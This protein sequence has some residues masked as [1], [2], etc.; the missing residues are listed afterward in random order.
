MKATNHYRRLFAASL[1]ISFTVPLSYHSLH[2]YSRSEYYKTLTHELCKAVEPKV[3]AGA[4]REPLEY[5]QGMMLRQEFGYTPQVTLI[6]H[7]NEITSHHDFQLGELKID[8]EFAG[9][10]EVQISITYQEESLFR[11]KYVYLYL[12]SLPLFFILFLGVRKLL[13]RF[14]RR[15]VDIVQSQIQKSLGL[16][17]KSKKPRGFFAQLLNL[18]IPLLTYLNDHIKNLENQIA[19]HTLQVTEQRE[20][21]LMADVA[22]QVA[23]DIVA[24]ISTVQQLLNAP[25][26]NYKENHSIVLEELERV[27][28]LAQ[29]MLRQ[30]R[31]EPQDEQ[32][33]TVNLNST[34]GIIAREAEVYAKSKT[35][36]EKLVPN[37]I[38]FTQAIKVEITSALSNIVKNAVE[39]IQRED[40]RVKIQLTKQYIPTDESIGKAFITIEDNGC[41]I[42]EENIY[43]VFQKDVSFKKG[44]T[45]LGLYQA[46][47]A[48]EKIGGSIN[49]KSSLGN[50]TLV[51]I[52]LPLFPFV[53]EPQI[54]NK[55]SN[56]E[57][58]IN[59]S[60]HL[61]FLDDEE[62][63]H[64]TW[65]SFLP[66]EIPKENLHFFYTT[67]DFLVWYNKNKF[68]NTYYFFDQDIGEENPVSGV[69][70]LNQ[71][72][73]RNKA[74]L[75]TGRACDESLKKKVSDLKI[76]MIDK[77]QMSQIK[78]LWAPI[79]LN[80][81]NLD[82]VL[83]DDNK[84]NRLAWEIEAKIN[85]MSI[86]TFDT[87]EAFL[88]VAKNIDNQTP[89]F[90][91][92][93]FNGE[94]SGPKWA[95]HILHQGYSKVYLA[96][97]WPSDK[98]QIPVGLL[99]V[100]TKDFPIFLKFCRPN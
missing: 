56:L 51:E 86:L 32:T 64:L 61:V 14:Q 100:V 27:K 79:L 94:K 71:L 25:T 70:L 3:Q 8:C 69:D 55:S 80:A 31:G 98:I 46:K 41:G 81:N 48:I 33:E 62:L 97:G 24:P 39:S 18:N 29:K 36:I 66:K 44:G 42:P 38:L 57:F 37:E 88:S 16:E 83:I 84:A 75:I 82:L 6:D 15:V 58:K 93:I 95:D 96:T 59:Q 2:N 52:I 10:N 17:D 54:E 60:T 92:Y 28:A 47:L 77:M 35:Q 53:I 4:T 26:E 85:N 43:K 74:V 1:I 67:E 12:I 19:E 9:F 72:G 87:A 50:G 21:Q 73:V 91:D 89:I 13:D 99:S 90:V 78:I 68:Q 63:I 20:T 34:I 30:Y 7:S 40:G 5:I 22:A 45:G 65:K 23:H 76:T 11:L 49:I